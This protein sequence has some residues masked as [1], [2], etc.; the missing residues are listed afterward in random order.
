[1]TADAEQ[2]REVRIYRSLRKR[3][4][5]LYVD[6]AEDLTRV[7]E[8]LL[9]RFGRPHKAMDLLLTPQRPLARADAVVVLASIAEAGFFLQL[10]PPLESSP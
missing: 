2:G 3:D 4:M 5:Y 8:A 7:P 6:A 1:M 10:P 9:Q